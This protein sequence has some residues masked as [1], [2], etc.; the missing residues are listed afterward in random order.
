MPHVLIE[1]KVKDYAAW[2]V[3]FDDNADFR[4]SSGEKSFHIFRPNGNSN[5]LTLLFEWSSLKEAEKFYASLE[6][7]SAMQRAGVVEEPKIQFLT[8]AAKGTA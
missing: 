5:D 6:L 3:V 4:R 7:K 2:K 8:E 1:H